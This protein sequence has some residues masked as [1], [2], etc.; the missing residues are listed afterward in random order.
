MMP[1]V[2]ADDLNNRNNIQKYQHLLVG[3]IYHQSQ[4]HRIQT[5]VNIPVEIG[6]L[7]NDNDP[8]G[9]KLKI[10][11]VASPSQNVGVV[12]IN[13][14][15]TVTFFPGLDYAGTVRFSYTISDGEGNSDKA[16]V[17]VIIK[18]PSDRTSDQSGQGQGQGQ[19]QDVQGN[20]H[21]RE[22]KTANKNQVDNKTS[23]ELIQQEF[24]SGGTN[25]TDNNIR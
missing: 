5:E 7:V 19:D 17:S 14:N 23:S 24:H 16:K 21:E 22:V 11:S 6:I 4:P 10:T 2:I 15:D 3:T 12:T 13:E 1:D 8:D 9:D 20:Q 18:A 25:D